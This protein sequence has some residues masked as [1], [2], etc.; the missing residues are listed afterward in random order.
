[1]TKQESIAYLRKRVLQDKL[2]SIP[3]IASETI[4]ELDKLEQ[5]PESEKKNLTNPEEKV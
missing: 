4:E 2:A 1:M 3:D 5:S